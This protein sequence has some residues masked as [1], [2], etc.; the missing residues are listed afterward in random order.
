M[1]M[2]F[3]QKRETRLAAFT[4]S[5]GCSPECNYETVLE[6]GTEIAVR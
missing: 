1:M 4:A 5:T 6:G 2:E 3:E